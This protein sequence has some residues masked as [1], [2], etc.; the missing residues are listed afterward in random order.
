MIEGERRHT[1][2]VPAMRSERPFHPQP[3]AEPVAT[4]TAT[5]RERLRAALRLIFDDAQADSLAGLA[6]DAGDTTALRPLLGPAMTRYTLNGW[7]RWLRRGTPSE[8]AV[9]PLRPARGA[10]GRGALALALY[11]GLGRDGETLADLFGVTPERFGLEL[12]R[13]RRAFEPSLAQPCDEWASP[14]ARFDDPALDVSDRVALMKHAARCDACRSAVEGGRALDAALRA[15]ADDISESLPAM[16]G[17]PRGARCWLGSP[18]VV[19]VV[20]VVVVLTL[21]VVGGAVRGWI[22]GATR[23]PVPLVVPGASGGGPNGWLLIGGYD[24]GVSAL[25]LATGTQRTLVQPDR[26]MRYSLPFLSPDHQQLAVWTPSSAPGGGT[27]QVFRVD[28]TLLHTWDSGAQNAS[29]YV[30][31]WLDDRTLL[32]VQSPSLNTQGM[33]QAEG[34]TR[35]QQETK[36]IAIDVG[37]GAE[38]VLFQGDVSSAIPSP[39]GKLVAI[40]SIYDPTWLG[41][42][43]QL[44]PLGPD[45]LGAPIATIEHRLYL[46]GGGEIWAP[47]SSRLYF[48]RIADA[49]VSGNAGG[50]ADNVGNRVPNEVDLVAMDRLGRLATLAT[51]TGVGGFDVLGVSPDGGQVIYRTSSRGSPGTMQWTTW[52]I[53][54][55]GSRRVQLASSGVTG[56]V[57]WLPADRTM[58]LTVSRTYFLPLDPNDRGL[59]NVTWTV[60]QTVTPNGDAQPIFSTPGTLGGSIL[61]WLPPDALPPLPEA[62]QQARSEPPEPVT[63]LSSDVHLAPYSAASAD[64]NYVVLEDDTLRGPTIWNRAERSNRRIGLRL[65][66]LSWLPGQSMVIGVLHPPV[67]GSAAP[68]SRITFVVGA[69]PSSGTNDLRRF[70]PAGIGD[71]TDRYYAR[72]LVS[73]DGNSV[74]FFVVDGAKGTTS[75]W[76][77]GW[78]QAAHVVDSWPSASTSLGSYPPLA[79]WTSRDTLLY[80]RPEA[81]TN[82]LPQRIK[83][84]RL[85]VESGRG[86]SP[87]TVLALNVHGGERGIALWEMA[88]SPDRVHLA[89]RLRH[90]TRG[91]P[92]I[93]AF[94]TISLV[95][96][97]DASQPLELARGNPGDGISWSPGGAWLATALDG[98]ITLFSANGRT[99]IQIPAGAA[100]RAA[101]VWVGP[102]TFWFAEGP[103]DTSRIMQ[104]WLR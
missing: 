95:E 82:G 13:A 80:A 76:V 103:A 91:D 68:T 6:G 59:G 62:T 2:R 39:D 89:Y 55:D 104:V 20:L 40:V 1:I 43:L 58:I 79:V 97:N 96:A 24:N 84:V 49:D 47:D 81:G 14:A 51:G 4:P 77:A 50:S 30:T 18:A 74:S 57:T 102:N 87:T 42:T 93:G 45:G 23:S 22:A 101:P 36:L 75:L 46:S 69:F 92:N 15:R 88:M 7:Y 78:D 34:I 19:L 3:Y 31:G 25:D 67:V 29:L 8:G 56:S 10:P 44:R 53:N 26:S 73:P 60:V 72:P 11:T 41:R 21:L 9:R 70:D 100:P 86:G 38:R 52:S 83:L 33:T 17:R 12:D 61:A 71:A 5:D 65:S 35:L 66:D 48:A 99:L 27:I 28:G 16:P 63:G 54:S 32:A 94:D 37:T 85:S 98:Q 90:Y 64:G